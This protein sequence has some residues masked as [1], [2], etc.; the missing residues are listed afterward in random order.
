MLLAETIRQLRQP[1]RMRHVFWQMAHLGADSLPIVGLTLLFTGM[2]M[3]LQIAHEFIRFGAQSTIGG[4]LRLRSYVPLRLAKGPKGATLKT[5]EGAC[6]NALFAPAII[7][8]PLH[9]PELKNFQ[10]LPLQKVY[11][12][13]IETVAGQT[14]RL[15]AE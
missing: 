12:Y 10:Q 11:E 1:P 3:T 14:Y 9:S 2:V 4:V 7:R 13:D 8:E 5:A 6:P 15:I